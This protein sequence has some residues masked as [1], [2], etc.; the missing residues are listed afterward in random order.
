MEADGGLAAADLL[1][2][3]FMATSFLMGVVPPPL[4]P[5]LLPGLRT[6]R[7]GVISILEASCCCPLDLSGLKLS[8]QKEVPGACEVGRG[9][10]LK[11]CCLGAWWPLLAAWFPGILMMGLGVVSSSVV[12]EKLLP[13][14]ERPPP[15]GEL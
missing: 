14:E 5:R 15:E 9:G 1:A 10:V 12:V 3:F 7:P 2:R 8:L 11:S 6:K 4:A 13:M